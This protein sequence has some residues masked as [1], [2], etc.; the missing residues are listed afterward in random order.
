MKPVTLPDLSEPP[1]AHLDL[2]LP[3]AAVYDHGGR[4]KWTRFSAATPDEAL[5]LAK[6]FATE[7]ATKHSRYIVV[8]G[9]QVAVISMVATAMELGF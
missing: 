4:E 2:T 5:A 7:L 3:T 6:A 9:A 8:Y 1:P